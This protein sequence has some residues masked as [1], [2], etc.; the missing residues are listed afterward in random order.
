MADDQNWFQELM[1]DT[2][3]KVAEESEKTEEKPS[4]LKEIFK[5][6][7]SKKEITED[8]V[9]ENTEAAPSGASKG[10][11]AAKKSREKKGFKTDNI[12][13]V[14]TDEGV[15]QVNSDTG[16]I[17]DMAEAAE[18]VFGSP[19]PAEESKIQP[20][21]PRTEEKQSE[22]SKPP[23]DEKGVTVGGHKIT[24]A[25]MQKMAE[26]LIYNHEF[27]EEEV[28]NFVNKMDYYMGELREIADFKEILPED[29]IEVMTK[30]D[31]A[32]KA[33]L[34]RKS[35]TLD[36]HA[37]A[38]MQRVLIGYKYSV[39]NLAAKYTAKSLA[40][41]IGYYAIRGA[42]FVALSKLGRSVEKN[43]REGSTV[44]DRENK[45]QT[46]TVPQSQVRVYYSWV[47]K[48]IESLQW[49]LSGVIDNISQYLIEARRERKVAET[50]ER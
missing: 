50:P 14:K 36:P 8:V 32:V 4:V 46:L 7:A 2:N 42:S 40:H 10:H 48:R 27:S 23:S 22:E 1:E 16:E 39:G 12:T 34:R 15:K 19:A 29:C 43:V 28:V 13:E 37:L 3:M 9:S 47:A 31:A 26:I 5:H 49:T 33:Y 25:T 20:P 44:A 24:D 21:V 6:S 41:E 18:E 45:A 30:A 38:D 35:E 11:A 17:V